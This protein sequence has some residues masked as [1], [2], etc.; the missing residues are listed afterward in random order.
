[1]REIQLTNGGVAR[2]SDEDYER[3]NV[4]K[5]RKN[6]VAKNLTYAVRTVVTNGKCEAVYMHR[7]ILGGGRC[8]DHIDG[9]GL[10]NVRE[11]IRSVTVRQNAQN[12]HE[13]KVSKYVGVAKERDK[14][15]AHIRIEGKKIRIGAYCIEEDARRAYI[16]EL[17]KIGEVML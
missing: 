3:I 14:W 2:V 6:T 10:N 13:S 4:N 16:A 5:W 11:N 7:E 12:R 17:Q 1:V 15:M 8:T 9:D